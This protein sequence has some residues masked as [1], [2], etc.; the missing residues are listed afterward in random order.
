MKKSFWEFGDFPPVVR[1]GT[2]DIVLTNPWKDGSNA[3]PFDQRKCEF[4]FSRQLLTV[5]DRVLSNPFP[6]CWGNEWVVP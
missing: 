3:A 4:Q 1:N 6:W 5:P 2:G